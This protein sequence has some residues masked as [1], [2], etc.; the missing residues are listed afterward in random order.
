MNPKIPDGPTS[1]P[2]AADWVAGGGEM[3]ELIRSY[4]WAS[5]P[6]GPLESWPQS[7]RSAVSILL[8]SGAQIAMFWGPELITLYNDA[9][10]PVLGKKHPA[11]LGMP[12]KE[13]WS[14]LWDKGLQNLFE[15]VLRT[16]KAFWADDHP[17][18]LERYGFAEETFF[19]I[20]YDPIRDE[21]GK[22]GG[23]FCIVSD[24][25][26]RV[27]SER[28]L[29]TLRDLSLAA[30]AETKSVEE[31]CRAVK[32]II[33]QNPHDIP[34]AT[35]YLLDSNGRRAQLVETSGLAPGTSAAPSS[36]DFSPASTEGSCWPFTE[37]LQK[38]TAVEV[39]DVIERCGKLS[40]GVWPEPPHTAVVIPIHAPG[41]ERAAG[42]LVAGVSPRR[43]FDSHYRGFFDLLATQIATTISNAR[44]YEEERRRA[45][46][47]AEL[48]RAKTTFFSNVSHEFRT[49]LTLMLG[50]VSDLLSAADGSLAEA[51]R[52]R[53]EIAHRNGLR[54]HK[55]VN[56]LLD[57]SRIEAGRVQS[58]FEP[59]DLCSLTADLASNFR[60]ACER[61]G[62]EL[63]VNCS[64]DKEEAYVDPDMWEK[65]VLNLLSNAFKYTLSG[66]IE[67]RLDK[68]A[69][70][71]QLTVADTGVGIPPDELPRLFERFHRV[72]DSR[73][74]TQEG[75][76]IGLALVRELVKLHGGS[77]SVESVVDRG[78]VFK[79]SIPR[80]KDH[81]PPG[82]LRVPSRKTSTAQG[83]A[84][85]V[86]EA[87]RWLP[88]TSQTTAGEAIAL[89]S[90][91]AQQRFHILLADDNADM[92]DYVRR[93]LT[94]DYEVETVGD[95]AAAWESMQKRVPD[96]VLSDVMMPLVDGFELLRRIRADKRTRD[97]PVVLL[98][99]RAGE[100]SRIEGLEASADDY[101]V[102]P[103][104][105]RELLAT[106]GAHVKM[107]ELRREDREALRASEQRHRQLMSL[108]P[109]AVYTCASPSGEITFFNERAAELWGREPKL[110]D[111]DEVFCGSFRLWRPDGS[112]LPYDETPMAI[113]VRDGIPCRNQAVTIE[114]PDGTR[115]N[116]I[117]NIDPLRDADGNL[118]GA[119]NAFHDTTAL[120]V[121]QE[122]LQQREEHLRA[123]VDMTPAC[124]KIVASDGT[125]LD[126]N[127]A[128][129][130]LVGAGSLDQVK[131]LS[132]YDLISDEDRDRFQSFNER[133]CSGER[134]LLEFDIIGL[135]GRR[136]RMETH[137]GPLRGINGEMV[138]LAVTHDITE[139]KNA[140]EALR[141]SEASHRLIFEQSIDGV[142][143]ATRDG[144]YVDV[145][146]SGCEMFGM[147]REEILNSTFV[148]LLVPE[149]LER[150][151]QA[152]AE[153]SDGQIHHTEWRFRRK[154][155]S[156]FVGEVAGRELPDGRLQG[157]VRDITERK[158][159]EIALRESKLELATE[160][161]VTKRLHS[162]SIRL[163]RAESLS[164]ALEDL[165][166]SAI[167]S[168]GAD[169]GNIQLF[170]PQKNVLEIIAQKGFQ[171]EF[172][173]YFREVLLDHGSICSLAM[174]SNK[175]V[176][177]ED[178]SSDPA[179]A[180]HRDI[181]ASAGFRA[182]QSTPLRTHDGKL[183][184]MLSTHFR[185]PTRL[186][187]R[188]E[189]SLDLYARHA[190]DLIERFRYED[191]LKEADRRKDEFLA[192]LAH[193]LRNPLA[194]ITN[195]LQL[196]RLSAN[197]PHTLH[198][199]SAIIERQVQQMVRLVDDL[200][201]VARINSNKLELRK[202]RVTFDQIVNSALETSRPVIQ[203]GSHE[204]VVSL[205]EDP[206]V[207]DADPIRLAQVLCNLLNNAAK[208]S[209]PQSRI[210]L[211]AALED[212]ELVARVRDTGLGLEPDKLQQIFDMF[213]QVGPSQERAQGGL[214]I[215]LTLV[216]RLV[217]M[218]GGRI[219]AHSEGIGKGSEFV[220]R[221]PVV[222][223]TKTAAG[224]AKSASDQAHKD[225]VKCRVLV[226]DDNVDSAESMAMMLQLSGHEVSMAHDGVQAI[227]LAR[228]YQPDVAFLDLGMPKLNGY[229]AARSIRQH[230]WG[231][232][233]TLIALTGWG[234]EEDKRRTR[235]AGFDDH[236]VKPID[237]S[238]L[239]QLLEKV[240]NGKSRNDSN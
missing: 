171:S 71:F 43:P 185:N 98:S 214:G 198:D 126:M 199:A 13:V 143:V 148:D 160:L 35:L 3:G 230:G 173:E 26:A 200:L 145:S 37:V 15:D 147:T 180:A 109:V 60:A 212:G 118:V 167:A 123:I 218:H 95:G 153:F 86:S 138:Q 149:E 186:T 111:R 179:F 76:G 219:E 74:R 104:S 190:A 17:F 100:E 121:T 55:L 211:S 34:F 215:G 233:I 177:S 14:E 169:F 210:R 122:A 213:V 224:D 1:T 232:K 32:D 29:K 156:V 141:A 41:Q 57:F 178:V 137:A 82:Q 45:E 196:I 194:P 158:R 23:L 226:V 9:Y 155:G 228:Q 191:A 225:Q 202:E 142:F 238:H 44:A 140:D 208:Y 110:G 152:V 18:Y 222:A 49:P 65:I 91:T 10:R 201:D 119:I 172:L 64:P 19:D 132:V 176:V 36:V 84:P 58:S 62:L 189:R 90:H 164:V 227:E 162:L 146:P 54:L 182:V 130:V 209:Q 175:R 42:L 87:L 150:L 27:I 107:S 79:V 168:C 181:A 203:R 128:G 77:V 30:A 131:D 61:A 56:T 38:G 69:N 101:L 70:H 11:A 81:L 216:K 237:F 108:L 223:V 47:L 59:T 115:I 159:A 4:N 229:D 154:D 135:D 192:T 220:M 239:E 85:F 106:V 7:L 28:Q 48:D 170:N 63:L 75:S 68:L 166:N 234:Q 16:G 120:R 113:A 8:P 144:H 39:T 12:I 40:C 112:P 83:A 92:R 33:S 67:V 151:P 231:K 134:G 124:I 133:I 157:I 187:E 73:G 221:L 93:L 66:R 127:Q 116:V 99:A 174:M 46:M 102:K 161:E 183:L 80:G 217:E 165:L 193:E 78:S 53:L 51:H 21:T 188:D 88:A 72:E 6:L 5:T 97:I 184:G 195:G 207:I 2:Q 240:A 96:L 89:R 25:T 20:S 103:F 31:A 52:E 136:R 125:L 22:V 206:V 94:E 105:A 236:V 163:G 50:P 114:R 204:L 24:M 129:L 197:D 117:V 205:P 235:E 139:R